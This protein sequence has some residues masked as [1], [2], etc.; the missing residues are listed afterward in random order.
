MKR[1]KLFFFTRQE[2]KLAK[3]AVEDC[4]KRIKDGNLHILKLR[5]S[6]H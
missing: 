4:Y 2:K 1:D 3:Q 5:K 6:N